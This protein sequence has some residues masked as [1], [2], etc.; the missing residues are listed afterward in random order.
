VQVVSVVA[1]LALAAVASC[2]TFD[3]LVATL[4]EGA[5]APPAG[6]SQSGF[7]PL[8]D[9]VL[10]CSKVTGCPHLAQSIMASLGV[11]LDAEHF[12]TCVAMASNP[13]P[14]D[15]PGRGAQAAFLLCS[16]QAKGCAE[17]NLCNWFE[18]VALD[19]PRCVEALKNKAAGPCSADGRSEFFYCDS[20]YIEHCDN[21][22][23]GK[24]SACV[25]EAGGEP[26]CTSK[27]SQSCKAAVCE[28]TKLHYCVD[29]AEHPEAIQ[30]C[31]A[32]GLICGADP[33]G[34]TACLTSS[35]AKSCSL[36]S[37]GA[38]CSND[39]VAVCDGEQISEFNCRTLGGTCD[40]DHGAPHCA[41]PTDEC[42]TVGPG[43]DDCDGTTITLCAGGKKKSYDCA[44]VGLSCLPA[45]QGAP[46]RCG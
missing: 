46:A 36:E 26:F 2:S 34:N 44:R 15:H 4:D 20:G 29:N 9:A 41:L 42:S 28:G 14:A 37:A 31:A 38:A 32:R 7:L 33:L 27:A 45:A 17:A 30:D 8:D 23:Y 12:S 40:S 16:A 18:S 43:I 25:V 10:L 21:P 5:P 35:I 6:E 11:P 13:L 3:G 19:D 22:I 39:V 24:D 1:A